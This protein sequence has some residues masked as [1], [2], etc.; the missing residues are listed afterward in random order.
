MLPARAGDWEIQDVHFDD[1]PD[2]T[3]TLRHRNILSAI[4]GLWGDPSLAN[5]LVYRPRRVFTNASRLKRVYSE[6]WTGEWWWEIQVNVGG[7][8]CEVL[9]L[10]HL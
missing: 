4:R 2:E 9:S 3:F 7:L 10:T 5:Q 1:R 8:D 6:M